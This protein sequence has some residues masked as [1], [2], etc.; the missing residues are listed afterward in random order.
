M[1]A[2]WM[3]GDPLAPV[4]L[5][6]GEGEFGDARR[7]ALGDDLEALDDARHDFVLET[8]IEIFGVLA[9]DDQVDILNRLSTPARFLTGRR[10]A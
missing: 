2:L 8:R 7:R 4:G 3:A 10:L 6:V 1:F 5:G 9:N